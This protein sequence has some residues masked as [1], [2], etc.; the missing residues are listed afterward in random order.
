MN[1]E[2]KRNNG[3]GAAAA[4][5]TAHGLISSYLWKLNFGCVRVSIGRRGDSSR[6]QSLAVIYAPVIFI[7]QDRRHYNNKNRFLVDDTEKQFLILF[8]WNK[9]R[10]IV[11]H[12]WRT[13]YFWFVCWSDFQT[14]AVYQVDFDDRVSW[15]KSASYLL[16]RADVRLKSV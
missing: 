16:T 9:R 8:C 4:V 3:A 2:R 7:H 5:L 1:D 11:F 14:L 6:K 15:N 12:H 10:C 13:I